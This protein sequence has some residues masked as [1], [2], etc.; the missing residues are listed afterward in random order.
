MTG[1]L[2]LPHAGMSEVR[3]SLQPFEPTSGLTNNRPHFYFNYQHH[4]Q[5]ETQFPRATSPTQQQP[6]SSQTLQSSY[7]LNNKPAV[8]TQ[9]VDS[10]GSPSRTPDL[11]ECVWGLSLSLSVQFTFFFFS[12]CFALPTTYIACC[13]LSLFCPSSFA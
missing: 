7:I 12:F 11:T 5:L 2:F 8:T 6:S 9:I 10:R 13:M 3:Q 4:N 1:L